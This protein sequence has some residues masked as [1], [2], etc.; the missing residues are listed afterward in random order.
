MCREKG[1]RAVFKDSSFQSSYEDLLRKAKLPTLY[2]RRLQDLAILMFK[3]KHGLLPY[4]YFRFI[5]ETQ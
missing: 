4:I 1:L 3:V 2:N 5:Y